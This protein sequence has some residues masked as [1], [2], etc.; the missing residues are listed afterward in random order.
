MAGLNH[1]DAFFPQLN[2]LTKRERNQW[3]QIVNENLVLLKY[4]KITANV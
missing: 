3:L 2:L 1:E 4:L